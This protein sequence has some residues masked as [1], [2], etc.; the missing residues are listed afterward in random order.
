MARP[1]L[2]KDRRKDRLSAF[3]ENDPASGSAAIT[4]P[5]K[6]GIV[7]PSA[8]VPAV[9]LAQAV[10]LRAQSQALQLHCSYN[11]RG[12]KAFV[13][14]TTLSPIESP[15]RPSIGKSQPTVRELSH[16]NQRSIWE[17]SPRKEAKSIARGFK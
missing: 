17:T 4:S 12:V 13:R 5:Q 9:S 8:L 10:V 6:Y 16:L 3:C 14:S 1:K 7:S 11:H 2:A 15:R